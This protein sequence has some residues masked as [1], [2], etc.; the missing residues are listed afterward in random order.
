MQCRQQR[1]YQ[2]VDRFIQTAKTPSELPARIFFF[3]CFPVSLFLVFLFHVF[4]RTLF[5]CT[6]FLCT[7]SLSSQREAQR[8]RQ[9]TSLRADEALSEERA[10]VRGRVEQARREVMTAISEVPYSSARGC[11]PLGRVKNKRVQY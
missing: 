3:S 1:P 5:L 10:R 11:F 9:Q 6:L 8:L 4:V 2:Q 7:L